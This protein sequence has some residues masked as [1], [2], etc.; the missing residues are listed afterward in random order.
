[1]EQPCPS[2]AAALPHRLACS[3][4]ASLSQS[5]VLLHREGIFGLL[6][7]DTLQSVND[8]AVC[9]TYST[10]RAAEAE[11]L[12]QRSL[13]GRTR[14]RFGLL[15]LQLVRWVQRESHERA[16]AGMGEWVCSRVPGYV[17]DLAG[18]M[19]G[20]ARWWS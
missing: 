12:L 9:L 4:A 5:L 14:V 10:K 3:A 8:L 20:H 18:W 16:G 1:M 2:N 7:P 17:S 6:H 13:A 15:G 11:V 19:E